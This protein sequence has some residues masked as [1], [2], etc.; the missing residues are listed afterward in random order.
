MILALVS[1]FE[2]DPVVA[3]LIVTIVLFVAGGGLIMRGR[4]QL[5]AGS[6]APARTIET[7]K[8]DAEW[9]RDQTR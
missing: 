6:L 8:E 4:S 1:V 2:V 3:A 7:L 5:E 9:A